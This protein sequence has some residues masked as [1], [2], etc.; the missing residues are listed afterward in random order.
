MSINKKQVIEVTVAVVL[1]FA[2]LGSGFGWVGLA[3]RNIRK[4]S[5]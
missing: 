2:L 5:R 4:A 1:G 3:E